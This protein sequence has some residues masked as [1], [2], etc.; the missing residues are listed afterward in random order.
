MT[1]FCPV[2]E[3]HYEQTVN[4]FRCQKSKCGYK[5]SREASRRTQ[6]AVKWDLTRQNVEGIAAVGGCSPPAQNVPS[7]ASQYQEKK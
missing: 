4:A 2:G 5:R 3:S 7:L 1:S 6:N